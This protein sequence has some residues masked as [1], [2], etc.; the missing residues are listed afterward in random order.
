MFLRRLHLGA[1][2]G[3]IPLSDARFLALFD[4]LDAR[5]HCLPLGSGLLIVVT[6][7]AFCIRLVGLPLPRLVR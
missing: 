5:F 6:A 4:V 7:L 1:N 2:D 3:P